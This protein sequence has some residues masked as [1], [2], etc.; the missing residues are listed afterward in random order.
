MGGIRHPEIPLEGM[1]DTPPMRLDSLDI[2]STNGAGE[3]VFMF[4]GRRDPDKQVIKGI[5]AASPVTGE[6][7][8]A[9]LMLNPGTGYVAID[10]ASVPGNLCDI[11]ATMAVEY[12]EKIG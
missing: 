8:R 3:L 6:I 11:V 1:P 7:K 9:A 10:P 12:R 4:R 5:L 2:V